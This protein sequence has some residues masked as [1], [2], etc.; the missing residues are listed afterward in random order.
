ML[1]LDGIRTTV[2]AWCLNQST[3]CLEIL[4]SKWMFLQRAISNSEL[5]DKEL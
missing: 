3:A 4:P 5:R 1:G 2:W